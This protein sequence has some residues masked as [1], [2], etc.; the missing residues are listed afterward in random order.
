MLTAPTYKR[1]LRP[2]VGK[3]CLQF[4][5][6]LL[7]VCF[8]TVTDRERDDHAP[9]NDRCAFDWHKQTDGEAGERLPPG[10]L[11]GNKRKDQQNQQN[12]P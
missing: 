9:I 6:H 7:W 12:L 11:Y 8:P 4:R 5:Q 3:G 1:M 2:F 10:V